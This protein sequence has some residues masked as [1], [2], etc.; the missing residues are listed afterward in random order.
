MELIWSQTFAPIQ[1]LILT[2][3]YIFVSIC[4]YGVGVVFFSKFL[5]EEHIILTSTMGLL[6][7][8]VLVTSAASILAN[9]TFPI[10]IS[11]FI[12]SFC[13]Y[14]S[15]GIR[16]KVFKRYIIK[17]CT[18]A[19]GLLTIIFLSLAS[20]YWL[21]L[22]YYPNEFNGHQTYFSGI[23]LELLRADYASRLRVFENYP[24]EWA[25]Y[26]F[27]TGSL[28]TI[29][30]IVLVNSN[31]YTFNLSKIFVFLMLLI[32]IIE[33]VSQFQ[34]KPKL[35]YIYIVT[36]I[37]CF[38]M[39]PYSTWW[40][41]YTNNY[42]SI[43]LLVLSLVFIHKQE[44]HL[45]IIFCLLCF[46]LSTIRSLLPACCIIFYYI[47]YSYN[48]RQISLSLKHLKKCIKSTRLDYYLPL[49]AIIFACVAIFLMVFTGVSV[50]NPWSISLK[51]FFHD[52]WLNLSA[53]PS[54][55]N[56]PMIY[57]GVSPLY[58][59]R[60]WY[61]F[62]I[63]SLVT[64]VLLRLE[65]KIKTSFFVRNLLK[66]NF[67]Q[68]SCLI[69][70]ITLS[71]LVV[72]IFNKKLSL[73]IGTYVL[74]LTLLFLLSPVKLRPVLLV[75][76]SS[77]LVQVYFLIPAIG[78]VNFVSIEWL[79]LVFAVYSSSKIN[80]D[81]RQA[82]I[83]VSIIFTLLCLRGLPLNPMNT[84]SV[85]SFGRASLNVN[86]VN[87]P[88]LKISEKIYCKSDQQEFNV[89]LNSSGIRTYFSNEKIHNTNISKKFSVE[90]G[91]RLDLVE[92]VC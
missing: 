70:L 39:L 30:Q 57:K 27:F 53:N 40:S 14:F 75:F 89:F 35:F 38:T 15:R 2:F 59:D 33:Y 45:V 26:H 42:S 76:I 91:Y 52:G 23:S 47:V 56:D 11:T 21:N 61:I 68:F 3:S 7:V 54:L 22:Q 79:I 55:N 10:I 48:F 18:K 37:Y 84:F 85:D 58:E 81:H 80:F 43:L 73:L 50:S 78:V 24:L 49:L 12:S 60:I 66:I 82:I 74:P 83:F 34:K 17:R 71:L 44:N 77:S 87:I 4:C 67:F 9:F 13:L 25:K 92:N 20:L 46:G 90:P 51:D 41:L 28:A 64:L 32:G 36:L 65:Q 8:A 6:V 88:S 69:L 86:A 19:F 63:I 72:S 16:N 1:I 62:W 5:N 31:L 29:P